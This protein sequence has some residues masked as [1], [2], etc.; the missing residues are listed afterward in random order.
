M[1]HCATGA[2]E[3][4][5]VVVVSLGEVDLDVRH[6]ARYLVEVQGC[7]VTPDFEGVVHECTHSIP[8]QG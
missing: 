2:I 3:G 6:V 1:G 8:A 7:D 5:A 4:V